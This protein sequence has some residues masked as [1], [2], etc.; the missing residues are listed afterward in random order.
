[1]IE[2]RRDR[3]ASTIEY[4]QLMKIL[5][6]AEPGEFEYFENMADLI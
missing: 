2:M 1:M 5:E 4:K 3:K 6:I